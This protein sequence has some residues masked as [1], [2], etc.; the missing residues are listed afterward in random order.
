MLAATLLATGCASA[1]ARAESPVP[2]APSHAQN[3]PPALLRTAA[4]EPSNQTGAAASGAPSQAFVDGYRAWKNRDYALASKRLDYAAAHFPVLRDYALFYL[5]LSKRD[6]GDLAGA[7]TSFERLISEYPQSIKA[8][9]AEVSLAQ[10]Y[11][12]L[13]RASEAAATASGVLMH[14][15]ASW[16]REPA[17]WVLARATLAMGD[18]RGAYA[19]LMTLRNEYP[20]GAHDAEAR[21][22]A[23]LILKNHP[24]LENTGSAQYRLDEAALLL[25]EGQSAM[26]L[27]Q[28]RAGLRVAPSREMRA[29]F[30]FIEAMALRPRPRQAEAA[31]QEYLRLA[32]TGVSAPVA[33]EHLGLIYWDE[34]RTDEARR[35]FGEIVTRFPRS[36]L[37]PAAMLRIGRIFEEEKKFD[38]ARAEYLRLMRRYP[39][40]EA[41]SEARFRAPWMYY[42]TGRYKLAAANFEAIRS[43]T[44]S[45]SERDMFTYWRARSLEE[46]GDREQA[47]RIFK[48]LSESVGSNYYPA[49]AARRVGAPRPFLPASVAELP[50]L[51]PEPVV[52]GAAQF[53]LERALALQKLGL[54]TLAPGE[55]W[56]LEVRATHQPSLGRFVLAGFIASG[57]YY[58]AIVAASRMARR[59]Q[60]NSDV[61]ERIRYPRGYSEL[62]SDAARKSR[63]D[64]WFLFALIRQ[65]SL[66]NPRA[67]SVSDAR[68]LMQLLPVTARRMAVDGGRAD[69]RQLDLYDPRLNVEL[70]AAYLRMLLV[71]FHGDEMKTAAA[72]NA[73]EHAVE[74]WLALSPGSDDE[75]V[76]NI[77]YRET[78]EYVKKVIGGKREYLLLYGSNAGKSA[79]AT[80]RR[81][82]G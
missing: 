31:Y 79:S 10:V 60:L 52:S 65:E 5:G 2:A 7:A 33:L 57:A 23:Y 75:W 50:K 46:S 13:D 18:W 70:G 20:R 9:E 39:Y 55:L 43:R 72:Y 34:N 25:R 45:A 74:K 29:E 61:A 63:L 47:R 56:A 36:S 40:S 76:E 28:V 4:A 80:A 37:A 38:L 11:L 59:G 68:G 15:H 16:V 82:P 53:H 66:F 48:A 42:M 1:P 81:S 32:P 51:D 3:S 41:G 27:R 49:L 71:M 54:N 67:T 19:D 8:P 24:S 58:D 77:T 12:K 22:L 35:T 14:S 69:P 62:V 17:R 30:V 26:A 44:R 73:G 21:K 6:S 64:P 78:R